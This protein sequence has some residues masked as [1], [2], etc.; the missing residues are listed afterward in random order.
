M[1]T[2]KELNEIRI[3][4]EDC[5]FKHNDK[6]IFFAWTLE[7]TMEILREYTLPKE[8]KLEE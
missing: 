5:E 6:S 3:K 1:L 2:E 4:L 7:E 8:I